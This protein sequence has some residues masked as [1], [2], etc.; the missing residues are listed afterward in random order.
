MAITP[1]PTPP[2]RS[3]PANFAVRADAFLGALPLFQS[4]ANS[5]QA[6]VNAKQVTATNAANA[7]TAAANAATAATG[8]T[9]WVS[10]TTYAVGD[11]RFS[12]LNFLTY[13]RKT[14][15][16]GTTDPSLDATNWAQISGTGNVS[17]NGSGGI[18]VGAISSFVNPSTSSTDFT[19]I[20]ITANDITARLSVYGSNHTVRTNSAWLFGA[21]ANTSLVLGTNN[22]ERIRITPSGFVGVGT[23]APSTIFEV[24]NIGASAQITLKAANNGYSEL[25]FADTNS[26][27]IGA[28]SYNHINDSMNLFVNGSNRITIS[29]TGNFGAGTTTPQARIS[30]GSGSGKK[31][32]AFDG[33]VAAGQAGIGVDMFGG[34]FNQFSLFVGNS[35][36]LSDH[37]IAFG[38]LN[39]NT[40]ATIEWMR[41]NSSGNVGIGQS[42]PAYKLDVSGTIAS[43]TP[44]GTEATI[45]LWQSG[46]GAWALTNPANSNIFS[47]IDL[48]TGQGQTRFSIDGSGNVSFN[49]TSTYQGQEIG[50]RNKRVVSASSNSDIVSG[51]TN[52]IFS[53][54][55]TSLVLTIRTA[56][57]TFDIVNTTGNTISLSGTGGVSINHILGVGTRSIANGA[58][59]TVT[60]LSA[61][62]VFIRGSGIT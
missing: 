52:N 9:V 42:N 26:N 50:W 6:D 48:A 37:N 43:V 28:I 16:A 62:V 35:S 38:H 30:A 33:G 2:S 55:V 23:S 11:N 56:G 47:I 7:A 31:I 34:S 49:G 46:T 58:Y 61:T 36:L 15:G 51:F 1:L 22:L 59:V 45:R 5:L 8:V 19:N 4:E 14:A 18:D 39:T 44:S 40:N 32:L 21:D 57:V 17:L 53:S 20:L 25:Y 13:R 60:Y 10:G 27:T 29:S 3:D 24:A 54:G 41:I 12:P